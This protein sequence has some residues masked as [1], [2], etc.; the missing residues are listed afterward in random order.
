MIKLTEDQKKCEEV[1]NNW[2]FMEEIEIWRDIDI[3][4]EFKGLYQISN[5]GNI[6]SVDR[7]IDYKGGKKFYKGQ[8][9]KPRIGKVGY[10]YIN[11][12]R[13]SKSKTVKIH[14]MVA[15]MFIPNP[16]NKPCV[17][18]IDANKLNNR[19]DNLEWCTYKEN[20]NHAAKLGLFPD[21]KGVNHSQSKL[22][23]D[24]IILI[25]E[26]YKTGKYTH[27]RLGELF[28]VTRRMIGNITQLRNW[29]HIK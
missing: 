11:L 6:R 21:C 29:K 15:M 26:W 1:Y 23:D 20:S 28:F 10:Y 8:I 14:R 18:H 27:K 12:K 22:I 16:E 5:L 4:E 17:N 7:Y 25:R 2:D 24:D 9:R 13:N 19:A 3:Y